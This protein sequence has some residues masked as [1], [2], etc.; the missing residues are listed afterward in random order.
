MDKLIELAWEATKTFGPMF[1]I[2]AFLLWRD[3]RDKRDDRIRDAK[4]EKDLVERI[5]DVENYQRTELAALV[6]ATTAALADNAVV[7]RTIIE[8]L[9]THPCMAFNGDDL[10]ALVEARRQAAKQKVSGS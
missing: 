4:R 7:S 1:G 2:V 10:V 3:W 8:T 5:R 9:H 6:K